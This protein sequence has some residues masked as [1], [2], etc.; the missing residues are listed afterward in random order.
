EGVITVAPAVYQSR[1]QEHV[2]EWV[3]YPQ[4]NYE[5]DTDDQKLEST[6]AA[7]SSTSLGDDEFSL[8]EKRLKAYQREG[9]RRTAVGVLLCHRY[10]CPHLLLLQNTLTNKCVLPSG[11][12]KSWDKPAIALGNKLKKLITVVSADLHSAHQ[13]TMLPTSETSIEI[14][15]YLGEWWRV[16]L[17]SDPLPYLPTHVTR[18]KERLRLYQVTLPAKC[19]FHLPHHY[20]LKAVPIF[21]IHSKTYGLALSGLMHLL[22]RFR[23]HR[24]I[25]GEVGSGREIKRGEASVVTPHSTLY[26]ESSTQEKEEEFQGGEDGSHR[27]T[28]TEENMES[29]PSI[30]IETMCEKERF[31]KEE[32]EED[33]LHS[34]LE[35]ES[36]SFYENEEI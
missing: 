3:I 7:A 4:S 15:E 6:G 23:L 24:M 2:P 33:T 31:H 19:I 25:E 20:V 12:Y 13:L 16:E 28:S 9:I 26:E 8:F 22:C 18:P 34:I 10:D 32:E 17:Y 36:S 11:K 14:G 35:Q 1:S 29:N 5:Y 21:D 27:W 30:I